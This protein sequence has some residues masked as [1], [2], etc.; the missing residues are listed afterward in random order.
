LLGNFTKLIVLSIVIAIPLVW[1]IM[2]GWLGNFSYQVDIHPLI[3]VGSG[4][5][6]I[7]I[8]WVTLSYFGL[9]ASRLNPAETLKS[10]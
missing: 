1:W 6:L 10:E 3:F 4:L 5:V 9:K 7:S 8:S 2:D